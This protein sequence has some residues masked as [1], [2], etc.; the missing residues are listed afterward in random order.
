MKSWSR[1]PNNT[2]KAFVSQSARAHLCISRR[3]C[4][5]ASGLPLQG[6]SGLV[7]MTSASHAEGRQFDPGLVYFFSTR[8]IFEK[9]LSAVKD[10]SECAGR[11][12]LQCELDMAQLTKT[13][14]FCA[15]RVP[16]P[17]PVCAVWLGL[18]L[19]FQG[20]HHTCHRK[21]QKPWQALHSTSL[22]RAG[23][24]NE[25]FLEKKFH[26]IDSPIP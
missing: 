22:T 21:L 23:A 24:H 26:A 6:T 10:S 3:G 1:T 20:H 9:P 11:D 18:A 7:A 16:E 2:R 5:G 17:V 19:H 12:N 14:S 25:C 13:W 15:R 4:T 8:T